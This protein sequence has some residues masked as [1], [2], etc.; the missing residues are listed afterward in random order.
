MSKSISIT[1]PDRLYDALTK[2]ASESMDQ[3]PAEFMGTFIR[4]AS[5]A[6]DGVTLKLTLAPLP[7]GGLPLF[8]AAQVPVGGGNA[9]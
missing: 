6:A 7:A 5:M 2:E 4:A 8:D 1:L 9:P 3:G